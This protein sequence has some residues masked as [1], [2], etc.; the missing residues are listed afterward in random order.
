MSTPTL[1]KQAFGFRAKLMVLVGAH[2]GTYGKGYLHLLTIQ[3]RV[4][5]VANTAIHAHAP[6]TFHCQI[7][8][9]E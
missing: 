9:Y 4:T 3:C 1:S 2:F 7:N 6:G 8:F 5:F